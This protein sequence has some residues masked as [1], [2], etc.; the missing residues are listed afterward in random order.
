MGEQIV[1]LASSGIERILLI[2]VTLVGMA[3]CTQGVARV[4]T[5]GQWL[6]F[7]G[8]SGS[9]LGIVILGIVGM[10]L[11]GRPLPMIDTDRAALV[12]VIAIAA[13]KVAVAAAVPLK[14]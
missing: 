5:S 9:L 1:H 11:I 10:R 4:A 12:A 14:P 3:M 13:V 8:I 6:S 2:V 7:Q